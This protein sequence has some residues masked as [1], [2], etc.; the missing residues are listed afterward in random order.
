MAKLIFYYATMN[1]GKTSNLLMT[2]YS[3]KSSGK[4]VVLVKP[5]IDDRFGER[6]IK[7]RVGIQEEADILIRPYATV[8]VV[9]PDVDVVL[10][11]EAQF[12]SD[13]NVEALRR[14]TKNNTQVICFGLLT[15][16][17]SALFPGSKRLLEISDEFRELDIT[18]SYCVLC[19]TKKA[20]INSK[21]DKDGNTVKDG[22]DEPELGAED[23][24]RAVCWECWAR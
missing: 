12:L 10:V 11:D 4:K 13:K 5:S 18:G 20:T 24:Y 15:D 8:C 14:L 21:Y 19:K 23:K 17:K 22:S 7:S 6:T 16:Y 1:S 9:D 3:L 2:S